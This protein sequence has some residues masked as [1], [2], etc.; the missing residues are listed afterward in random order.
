[1]IAPLTVCAAPTAGKAILLALLEGNPFCFS[2]P[3]WHDNVAAALSKFV[4]LKERVPKGVAEGIYGNNL[5]LKYF[6][7]LLT[8]TEWSRLESVSL[9]QFYIFHLS[10][11]EQIRLPISFDFYSMDKNLAKTIWNMENYNKE[12]IFSAIFDA[13]HIA[14]APKENKKP[15]YAL[16]MPYNDFCDYEKLL[17]SF[18]QGRIIYIDR[19]ISDALG[20]AILRR[21]KLLKSSF[22]T[23]CRKEFLE[24]DKNFFFELV[25][26]TENIQKLCASH[27]DKILIVKFEELILE[28]EKTMRAIC[29]WLSIPF[30][31]DMCC[32]TFQGKIIDARATG[33]I[34]D[35]MQKL[36]THK[37][38]S[39]LHRYINYFKTT[40]NGK[41]DIPAAL[42]STDHT[43]A[44]GNI[45]IHPNRIKHNIF[46]GPYIS[47]P[48][49]SYD[50][51]FSFEIADV[52]TYVQWTL[53]CVD[54]SG[55]CYF[56]KTL[57]VFLLNGAHF[58]LRV[59]ET[60]DKNTK[61]EFRA[62]G[63]KSNTD[64]PVIFKGVKIS[65]ISKKQKFFTKIIRKFLIF[66]SKFMLKYF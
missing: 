17:V 1:M 25:S 24:G 2:T 14:I 12:N 61:F 48:P 19:D 60:V 15:R 46:H 43:Y 53:D 40:K 44:D 7:D 30:T 23:E 29:N 11:N 32:A 39:L 49:G 57:P 59:D 58:I 56:K 4:P 31:K 45:I 42:F 38:I 63:E 34:Q 20:S 9:Q 64:L 51:S 21:A 47:I 22:A 3:L 50:A 10:N 16:T 18:P 13:L 36:L 66:I 28:T 41:L 65:T 27:P 33:S 35:D 62:Y 8:S 6:R 54:T 37:E 26:R 55:N 52:P 5:Q